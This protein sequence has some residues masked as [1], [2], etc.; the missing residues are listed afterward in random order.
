MQQIVIIHGGTTF[1]DY[2]EYLKS[3]SEK[4]LDI[5]RFVYKP[6]WKELLQDNLGSDYQVLL[7]SMPNSTNARYSE[8]KLWFDHI[9]SLFADNCILVGHSL[10]AVFLAKYLSENS[11][12]VTIKATI[13]IAAPYDD[14]SV[15]DLT[16]F[17]I[18]KLS[19]QLIDQA[20]RLVFFNGEDDPVISIH[21][22]QKYQ[23][24]LPGA[25]FNILSAPDHFVRADFPELTSLLKDI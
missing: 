20:G 3:L 8:W 7:P 23:K 4:K 12:R 16:D 1:Q 15:E 22:L 13:L 10:G 24:Q 2:D 19:Q 14:E 18:T 17:K 21:D 5:D 9:S 11:L 25:E 6:K